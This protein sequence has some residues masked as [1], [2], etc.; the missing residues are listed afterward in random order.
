MSSCGDDIV[1][2]GNEEV[3]LF[4]GLVVKLCGLSWFLRW[5]LFDGFLGQGREM[6]L[7]GLVLTPDKLASWETVRWV[8][9]SQLGW[10]LYNLVMFI[11]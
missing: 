8:R 10:G 11:N 6:A 5:T 2:G 9:I 7:T 3:I 4:R 1:A